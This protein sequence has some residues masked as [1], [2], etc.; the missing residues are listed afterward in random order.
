MK[1]S[2]VSNETDA[3]GGNGHN[4]LTAID[5]FGKNALVENM[6]TN[7]TKSFDDS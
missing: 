6:N 1:S 7:N 2:Y 3:H 5:S 4:P